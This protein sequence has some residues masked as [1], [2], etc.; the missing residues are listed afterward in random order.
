[1]A[2][3]IRLLICKR[4]RT[5]EEVLDYEGPPEED[6]LLQTVVERHQRC[7]PGGAQVGG[8]TPEAALQG[9]RA[10]AR[11]EREHWNNPESRKQILSQLGMGQTGFEEHFYDV[12]NT[13]QEDALKCFAR[14]NR[15]KGDCIDYKEPSKLLGN[16]ILSDEEKQTKKNNWGLI[17]KEDRKPAEVYLCD[18]CPVKSTQQQKFFKKKGLYK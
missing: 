17:V 18:F 10:L 7:T 15:P 13:F 12:K 3:E 2:E 8:E 9:D 6:Y 1:M 5:V 11:V 14:H 16:A 4:C